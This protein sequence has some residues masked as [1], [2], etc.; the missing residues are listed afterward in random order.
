MGCRYCLT[1]AAGFGRDLTAAEIVNQVGAAGELLLA[2]GVHQPGE[3]VPLMLRR[4]VVGIPTVL[5]FD[6]KTGKQTQ[7][8]KLAGKA[9]GTIDIDDL[10]ENCEGARK[11]GLHAIRYRGAKD[12][13]RRLAALGL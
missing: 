2:E 12:L 7:Q 4:N 13:K 10:E 8:L 5:V 3:V 1:G 6:W 9:D 11:A